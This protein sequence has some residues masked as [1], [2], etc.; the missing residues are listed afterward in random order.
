MYWIYHLIPPCFVLIFLR[1]MLSKSKWDPR[2]ALVFISNYYTCADH[3]PSQPYIWSS[4]S[5]VKN[6]K[7]GPLLHFKWKGAWYFV[8]A[9]CLQIE[10]GIFEREGLFLRMTCC[11][12]WWLQWTVQVCK[13]LVLHAYIPQHDHLWTTSVWLSNSLELFCH[14]SWQGGGRWG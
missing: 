2:H 6:P 12:E 14:W 9:T 11:M 3:V 13:V 5:K 4:P 1:I 7:G 10:L 8:C